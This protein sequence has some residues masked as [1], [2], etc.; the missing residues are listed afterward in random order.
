MPG[1]LSSVSGVSSSFLFILGLLIC[2]QI[3]IFVTAKTTE[4]GK[5][6]MAP[7]CDLLSN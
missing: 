4:K 2:F 7:S 6:F 5:V 1:I 3:S